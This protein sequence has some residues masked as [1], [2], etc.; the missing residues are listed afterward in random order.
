MNGSDRI[1]SRIKSDC[2]ESVRAIEARAKREQ[3]AVIAEA[4]QNAHL[5]A[6]QIAEDAQKQCAQIKANAKSRAQL[7]TRN[8]L[9]K[10]RRTEIDKTIDGLNSYLLG[11]DDKEYF[12]AIY[13]LAA[14]LGGK[15]GVIML[16]RRDLNRLPGDF[17]QR[18]KAA[19]LDATVS[20]EPAGISGGFVLKSGDVEE[21]MEFSAMIAS[22]RD[23][24]EDFINKELF[25]Q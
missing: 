24:L 25:A 23:R 12:E 16:N 20:D 3:D 22:E 4:Q 11:L 2:D 7:E 1:L 13:R 19:G 9:L 14:K 10:Q 17:A 8:A 18:L 21:N 15:S 6:A 5:N